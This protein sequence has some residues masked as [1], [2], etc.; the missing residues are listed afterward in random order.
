MSVRRESAFYL[1]ISLLP[2][3]L[4]LRSLHRLPGRC[5]REQEPLS[6]RGAR[7]LSVAAS[8]C[9]GH[10]LS[11]VPRPGCFTARGTRAE[12]VVPP[13]WMK[14]ILNPW[15]G[16]DVQE[17]ACLALEHAVYRC[18]LCAVLGGVWPS[19]P[20]LCLQAL[21]GARGMA[22]SHH[23]SGF[24]CVFCACLKIHFI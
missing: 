14:R 17:E 5:V 20:D 7:L 18:L 4:G 8:R 16:R 6:G 13:H 12:P 1:C 23:H 22:A 11:A 2:A 21:L 9:P 10:E 19:L 3:L 24:I 15:T